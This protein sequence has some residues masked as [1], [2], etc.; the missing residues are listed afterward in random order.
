MSW[1]STFKPYE[2]IDIEFTGLRPGE[3]LYEELLLEGEGGKPTNHEKIQVA[4]STQQPWEPLLQNLDLL[5][6]ASQNFRVDE[7]VTLMRKLVPEYRP[8]IKLPMAPE[9]AVKTV[10]DYKLH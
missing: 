8:V 9:Q 5:Y 1:H 4:S 7:V 6:E 10:A 3:K 2:E